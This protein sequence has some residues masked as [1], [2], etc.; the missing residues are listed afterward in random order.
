MAAWPIADDGTADVEGRS[1]RLSGRATGGT[2][3]GSSGRRL[4]RLAEPAGGRLAEG[5][6]AADETTSARGGSRRTGGVLAIDGIQE[7]SG[8]GNKQLAGLVGWIFV[9]AYTA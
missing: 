2:L 7:H 1:G 8:Y 3:E 6:T 5:R 4:G 9:A